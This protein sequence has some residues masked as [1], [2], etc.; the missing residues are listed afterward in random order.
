V[1]TTSD[2]QLLVAGRAIEAVP[3][4]T[5]LQAWL[6]SGTPVTSNVGCSGQGVCGS[7]RALVRRAGTNRVSTELACVLVAEDGMHVSFLDEFGPHRSRSYEAA[8]DTWAVLDELHAVFPEAEHC[9]HCGGCDAVCPKGIQVEASVADAVSGRV[10]PAA[11]AFDLCVM[12]DLCT[13]ACPEFI[14]P[15]HLGL[16]LRRRNVSTTLRPADLIRRIHQIDQGIMR[17]DPER[18]IE[19]EP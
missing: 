5:V 18:P 11:A 6:D 7:C 19:G 15:N 2:H 13:A 16:Y 8:G 12:C 17:V 14:A 3:G 10:A 4:Q 1:F 9:R